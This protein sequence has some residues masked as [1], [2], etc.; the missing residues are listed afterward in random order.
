[1]PL[2]IRPVQETDLPAVGEVDCAARWHAYTGILPAD[3]LA[4]V[5]PQAQQE[6]WAQRVAKEADSHHMLVA[7]RDGQIVGYSYVGPGDD[8]QLGDLY[9]LFVHPSAHGTGVA[10]QLMSAS[11]A[12][13]D[14]LGYSRYLLWVHENNHQAIRFYEKSG[15]SHDGT[16]VVNQWGDYNLRYLYPSQG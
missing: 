3:Q 4:E 8:P 2:I 13:L 16:R 11:L 5:T 9:A 15:W 6:V 10:Q 1:M 7:E 12:I 14:S